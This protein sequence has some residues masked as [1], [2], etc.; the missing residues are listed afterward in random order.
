MDIDSS[1]VCDYVGKFL[2]L[3]IKFRTRIPT[4]W[5]N[6]N[7]RNTIWERINKRIIKGKITEDKN[8]K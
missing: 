4:Q 8:E 2:P 6:E 3:K 7:F 5:E 1:K